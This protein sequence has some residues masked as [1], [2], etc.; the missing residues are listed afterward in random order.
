MFL[1]ILIIGGFVYY[2]VR[3]YLENDAMIKARFLAEKY[4][5]DKKISSKE[6]IKHIVQAFDK[7]NDIGIK[8]VNYSLL[9]DV[10]IKIFIFCAICFFRNG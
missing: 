3:S 5:K 8:Y 2:F 6:E 1:N 7:L 4:M 9:L 10:A